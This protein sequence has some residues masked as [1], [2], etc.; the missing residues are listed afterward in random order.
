MIILIIQMKQMEAKLITECAV[1]HD[2]KNSG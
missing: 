2:E 1:G